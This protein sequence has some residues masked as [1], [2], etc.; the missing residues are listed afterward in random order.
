MST[1]VL[2]SAADTVTT[3]LRQVPHWIN[4]KSV[5]GSSG[6]SG[7]V[8]NPAIGKVQAAVPF[9]SRAELDAAVAAAKAAFPGWSA[10]PPLRRARVMLHYPPY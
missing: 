10:Q 8:Y 2:S 4:G 3:E 1:A 5:V 9:A 6:R 7:K